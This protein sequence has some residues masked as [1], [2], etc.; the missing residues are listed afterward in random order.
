MRGLL[1][2][3]GVEKN[4]YHRNIAKERKNENGKPKKN[5]KKSFCLVFRLSRGK[6][7]SPIFCLGFP[8]LPI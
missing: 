2:G 5:G 7:F 4:F 1:S 8:F 3:N 6:L